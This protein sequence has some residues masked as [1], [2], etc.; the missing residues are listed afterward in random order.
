MVITHRYRP[1]V[2]IAKR[3]FPITHSDD[4]TNIAAVTIAV[5]T[6][7]PVG[8]RGQARRGIRWSWLAD[9]RGDEVTS[10]GPLAALAWAAVLTDC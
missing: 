7:R 8:A 1:H 5:T 9:P 6:G 2:P 10:D 4:H 3:H